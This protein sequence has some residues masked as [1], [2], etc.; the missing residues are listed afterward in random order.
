MSKDDNVK[1][2]WIP[3]N[4]AHPPWDH[5]YDVAVVFTVRDDS[6]DMTSC[7]SR[8]RW[9]HIQRPCVDHVSYTSS[10]HFGVVATFDCPEHYDSCFASEPPHLNKLLIGA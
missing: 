7:G 9:E 6:Q 3:S 10:Q 8:I 5:T 1:T 4:M 2:Q